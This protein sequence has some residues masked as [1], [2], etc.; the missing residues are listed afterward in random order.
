M[1][2]QVTETEFEDNIDLSADEIWTGDLPGMLER[3]Q[4]RVLV[5]YSKTDFFIVDGQGRGFEHDLMQE[6]ER[7]LNIGKEKREPHTS[8]IYIPV[9]FDQLLLALQSG[10]GDIAAA[11]LTITKSRAKKIVFTDPYIEDVD[12]ILV[13]HRSAP[14]FIDWNEIAG[15]KIYVRRGSSYVENLSEVNKDLKTQGLKPL[16]VTEADSSLQSEDLLEMV[17]ARLIDY[18]V[19]DNHKAELWAKLLP[20]I[21]LQAAVKGH[22]GGKIAWAVR[23]DSPE[24]L[25]KLNQFIREELPKRMQKVKSLYGSYFRSTTWAKNPTPMTFSKRVHTLI[26]LFQGYSERYKVPWLLMMAQGFQESGLN[27]D[28]VS[29]VGA[30]GVMQVLPDTGKDMGFPDVRPVDPNIHAGIKYM[31]WI[32]NNYFIDPDLPPSERVYFAL[33]AYNAGPNRIARLRKKAPELGLDPN[34]WFGNMEVVVLMHVGREPVRY[35]SSINKYYIN[36]KT[37]QQLLAE[38][39]KTPMDI[40]AMQ[41]LL[42]DK[43]YDV[44]IADGVVGQRTRQ[45]IRK[46]QQ[47]HGLSETGEPS[48]SLM[49]HLRGG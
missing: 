13:T 38:H 40:T 8:V 44:G 23:K 32:V 11:G 12:E 1:A 28:T 26:P 4:V 3:E 15:A 20:D 22:L 19:I 43:G 39:G 24:L 29:P 34:R 21:K 48:L 49:R 41:S 18:A 10:R 33:A 45:A 2:A 6:F 9:A 35:V 46:Y 36:Y 42:H 31:R 5:T 27:P 37:M 16:Q 30:L 17:N 7:Y 14:D 47:D 25:A